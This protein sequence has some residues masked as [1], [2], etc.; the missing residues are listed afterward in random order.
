MEAKP[1]SL[2]LKR[3]PGPG[4]SKGLWPVKQLPG[5]LLQG[6]GKEWHIEYVKSINEKR[7][8]WSNAAWGEG[9]ELDREMVDILQHLKQSYPTRRA[10][11][12]ALESNLCQTPPSS[13]KEMIT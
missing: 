4:S 6:F 1:T 9:W 13:L 3:W 2:S 11:L 7:R 5:V 8:S 10:A 12:Y